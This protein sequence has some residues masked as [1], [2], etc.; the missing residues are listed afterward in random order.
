MKQIVI[1]FQCEIQNV[2]LFFQWELQQNDF[3]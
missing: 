2:N 1:M 3:K